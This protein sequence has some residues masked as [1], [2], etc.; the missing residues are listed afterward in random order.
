MTPR[1]AK[2]VVAVTP[3]GPITEEMILGFITMFTIPDRAVSASKLNREW[4]GH[5]LP[6]EFVPKVR[7]NV[8]TFQRACRSVET[9]RRSDEAKKRTEIEVDP[10][11]ET[12]DKCVYQITRLVRDQANEVIDHPKALKVIFDKHTEVINWKRIDADAFKLDEANA[13]GEA[14]RDWYDA[15]TGKI[16]AP[17]VRE[18]V[19]KLMDHLGGTN[20][21]K[22]AGGVYLVPRMFTSNVETG[23]EAKSRE[24]LDSLN[25]VFDVLWGG[26]AELLMLPCMDGDDER[27]MVEAHF[28]IEVSTEIDE[29][30]ATTT[31]ALTRTD[32][33]MRKD[34][35]GNLLSRFKVLSD[36]HKRY[37]DMLDTDITTV[38]EKL[39]LLSQQLEA[40][41]LAKAG[42]E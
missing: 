22:K 34:G 36:R 10:V 6:H 20:L 40:L 8:N 35:I 16:P 5:G 25:E 24:Y 14:I 4:I 3:G 28:D 29:L 39:D 21:R 38:R 42:D 23:D 31:D 27:S 13:I 2:N 9:R 41:V 17:R 7:R 37:E 26:D 19:R 11:S 1:R 18:A 32:R 12:A 30:M 33:S 15:N